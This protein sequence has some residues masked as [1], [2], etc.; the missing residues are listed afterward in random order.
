M[1]P[2]TIVMSA[3]AAGLVA[4]AADKV[5]AGGIV[6]ENTLFVPMTVKLTVSYMDGIKVKTAKITSKEILANA[7]AP[8]GA[9]L[10]VGP[11]NDVFVVTKTDV[12]TD[13]S[14]S[15]VNVL[16]LNLTELDFGEVDGTNGEFK[17]GEVG[18]GTLTFLSDGIDGLNNNTYSFSVTGQ[19]TENEKHSAFDN[20]GNYKMSVKFSSKAFSGPGYDFDVTAG[21]LPVTGSLKGNGSGKLQAMVP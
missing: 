8:K 12:I 14:D 9:T 4:F 5:Q 2:N 11:G 13:L 20:S 7:D 15:D 10:A 16:Y 6:I 18:L 21:E 19:Y 3:L 1:K 17:S